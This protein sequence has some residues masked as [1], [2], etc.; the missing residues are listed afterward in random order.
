VDAWVYRVWGCVL[1]GE[2]ERE[3]RRREPNE[4]SNVS[5]SCE[6]NLRTVTLNSHIML[7]SR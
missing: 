5:I 6:F 3:T 4:V 2:R 7:T 1:V